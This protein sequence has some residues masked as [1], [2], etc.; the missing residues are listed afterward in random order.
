MSAQFHSP[1]EP[2]DSA[3]S[4]G[5]DLVTAMKRTFIPVVLPLLAMWVMFILS[6]VLGNWFNRTLALNARDF[7]GLIGIIFMPLLHGGFG[8]LIGNT[9][10]WIVLGGMTS[11]LTKRFTTVMISLWLLSG[12]ILWIIGTPWVCHAPAGGG[13]VVNHI[14][15]STVIYGF[16]AFIV[17]YAILARRFLAMLFGIFVA[18]VYGISMLLGMLPITPGVSWTGHL[19]GAIAGVVV[20]FF[21]TKEAREQRRLPKTDPAGLASP[22]PQLDEPVPAPSRRERKQA[23]RSA[24]KKNDDDGELDYSKFQL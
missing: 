9:M 7:S 12:A 6:F 23:S 11:M 24:G 17:T 18:F 2:S 1:S 20:A 8:H 5:G 15:A 22:M 21:F 19:S 3:R 4:I 14:G 16:A 10:S 13:C